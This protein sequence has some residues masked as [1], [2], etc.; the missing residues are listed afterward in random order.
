MLRT[1]FVLA[2]AAVGFIYAFQGALYGLLFYLW[3][4]YFRPEQWV[5]DADLLTSLNLSYVVG[6]CA[7]A[8]TVFSRVRW[9]FN[10][11]VALM[12]LFLAHAFVSTMVGLSPGYAW[13]YWI[14]FLKAVVVSY[15]IVI[16]VT[17]AVQMRLVLLVIALSLGFEAAK[18]GWVEMLRH[19]GAPN[20]NPLPM[21]GDNNGVAVGM[22]MLVPIL[23][24]LAA[25]A[26]TKYERWVLWFLALGVLYRG[27]V[28]Y[29]RGGFL[30]AAAL[31]VFYLIR[32]P[33]RLTA[34]AGILVAVMVI[35]PVLPSAFWDRM[36]TIRPPD[37][38]STEASGDDTSSLSRLHFWAV[39]I[40]MADDRPLVGV[41]FNSFNKTYDRYDNSGEFGSGRS[42][43]SAW[44][45]LLSEVGYPGLL[46]FL[47]L[48]GLAIGS[49]W[50]ARAAARIGP[51]HAEL[52][53][54]AFAIE[55]ALIVFAVGGSFLPVQ[56]MEMV[57]HVF[58]LAIALDS[59]ARGAQATAAAERRVLA[60]RHASVPAVAVAS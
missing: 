42:V 13:P 54:F 43:H 50:R 58:A 25:M 18:Q 20:F 2:I 6:I 57:W 33:K 38:E 59:M 40:K 36:S 17:D 19:P 53:H 49:C 5:W 10:L 15:L 23:T 52:V 35:V 24:S 1:I 48:F 47:A 16:L 44:F 11:R 39:A 51:E 46:L 3:I 41:G 26:H 56:Y 34:L 30:A 12:A 31:G 8:A 22:L 60:A 37:T 7:L 21:L 29:S 55:A 9:Q 4:A 27:L 14:E 32:S 45:G 28:T